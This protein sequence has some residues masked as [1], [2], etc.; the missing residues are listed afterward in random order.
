M[1]NIFWTGYI[2]AERHSS[3]EVVKHIITK[4]GHIVD[5][6]FYSDLSLTMTIE[7]EESKID[8][9]YEELLRMIQI[10]PFE[11]L[12]SNLDRERIVYLNITFAQGTGKL[13]VE[14]PAV[15]G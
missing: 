5:F 13:I 6:K 12:Y 7:I 1:E 14:V 2:N 4:Y 9:L 8:T 3:I 10:D 15:P 11:R